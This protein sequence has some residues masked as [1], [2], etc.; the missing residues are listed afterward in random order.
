MLRNELMIHQNEDGFAL[1]LLKSTALFQ[2][3]SIVFILFSF[4]MSLVNDFVTTSKLL[5]Y[6]IKT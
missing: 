5:A 4:L 3:I 2:I 1:K 6:I